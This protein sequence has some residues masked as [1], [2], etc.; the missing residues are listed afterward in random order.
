MKQTIK[1]KS[2]SIRA[3]LNVYGMKI[4]GR[5]QVTILRKWLERIAKEMKTLEV[6][7]YTSNP[8]WTLYK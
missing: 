4:L 8:R 3:R 5:K 2:N 1:R 6:E 7:A